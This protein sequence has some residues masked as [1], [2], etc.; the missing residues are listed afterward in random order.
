MSDYLIDMV[1]EDLNSQRRK[2]E[3]ERVEHR[4]LLDRLTVYHDALVLLHFM[5]EQGTDEVS[6]LVFNLIDRTLSADEAEI[7][8][9]AEGLTLLKAF[10]QADVAARAEEVP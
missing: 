7:A 6:R 3:A 10:W 1:A 4:K 5:T 9:R 2:A 8:S